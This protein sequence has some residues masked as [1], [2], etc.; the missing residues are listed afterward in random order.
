MPVACVIFRFILSNPFQF[1]NCYA[2]TVALSRSDD[3]VFCERCGFHSNETWLIA[4]Q[5]NMKGTLSCADAVLVSLGFIAMK[6]KAVQLVALGL[7]TL[8]LLL[9][10][11]GPWLQIE[12]GPV[13]LMTLLILCPLAGVAISA[14][15]L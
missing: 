4:R 15:L 8:P 2:L 6:M 5:Q 11:L 9:V 14:F 12:L 13:W 1:P 7:A 10:L 3:S